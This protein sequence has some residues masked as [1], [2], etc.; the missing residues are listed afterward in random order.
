MY[1]QYTYMYEFVGR[2]EFKTTLIKIS[3]NSKSN[4][5]IALPNPHCGLHIVK[6]YVHRSDFSP[7]RR[8]HHYLNNN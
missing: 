3:M 4:C 1:T 2:V 5:I 6:L 8:S 7:V